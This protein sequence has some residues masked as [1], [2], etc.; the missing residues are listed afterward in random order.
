MLFAQVIKRTAAVN[1]MR[2]RGGPAQMHLV[3]VWINLQ[4]NFMLMEG[5]FFAFIRPFRVDQVGFQDN[6]EEKTGA[7]VS[8]PKEQAHLMVASANG[9]ELAEHECLSTLLWHVGLG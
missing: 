8:D 3:P 6:A 5:H 4:F 1:D 2:H 9:G 7:N